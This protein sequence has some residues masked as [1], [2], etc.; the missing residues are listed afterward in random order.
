MNWFVTTTSFNHSVEG[1]YNALSKAQIDVI[2]T[3]T[4]AGW[5]EILVSWPRK[6]LDV[7]RHFR[8]KLSLLALMAKVW[9]KARSIS[10]S[11][12]VLLQYPEYY[13]A[14]KFILQVLRRR[15]SHLHLL[16]HDVDT[17]RNAWSVWPREIAM[18]RQAERLY[19]HTDSMARA[20]IGQ[21]IDAERLRIMTLFD[22]YSDSAMPEAEEVSKHRNEVAFAG[23]LQKSGFISKLYGLE[24]YGDVVFDLF[25]REGLDIG[26]NS[27]VKYLGGFKPDETGKLVAG[28]GLVWDG[29]RT[30][31]CDGLVGEYLKYNSS[32]KISLYLACGIPLI[33]WSES[34]LRDWV[35]KNKA[36]ILVESL[37]DI[38]Q[39]IAS[40]SESDYR[41]MIEHC[42]LIGA[43]LRHGGFLK[44]A[45]LS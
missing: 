19:V 7:T 22:Y 23:N 1:K 14:D 15:T 32:H 6:E 37:A 16:V 24:S 12:T 18:F 39:K 30:D 34:S 31:T 4:D 45:L 8:T 28:W 41:E 5:K 33:L 36:G 44:E 17:L 26:D 38:P 20:L 11:D 21:G 29:D 40:L 13:R 42:R 10:R 3:L 43:K 25:G 2:R 27:H 9:L 35:E